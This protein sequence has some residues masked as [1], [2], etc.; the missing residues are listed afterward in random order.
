MGLMRTAELIALVYF[1]YL[2]V[3][4]RLAGPRRA[5]WADAACVAMAAGA[6]FLPRLGTGP[7]AN[8]VRDWIPGAFLLLGYWMAS[9]YKGPAWPAFERALLHL[10]RSLLGRA[11]DGFARRAPRLVLEAL[12]VAYALCY[13]FVP[14]G[15]LWLVLSGGPEDADRFWTAVLL[16]SLPCYGLLPW[17]HTAP[18]R[19][20][21]PDLPVERRGLLA[22]RFNF[23]LLHRTSVHANTFPSGHVASTVAVALTILASQPGAGAAFLAGAG[24]IAV[25]T[26]TGRYH[27]AADAVLGALL[28]ALGFWLA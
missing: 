22:R 13:P 16:A 3:A 1:L 4:G 20:V 9:P 21:E 28:G 17:F 10:D 18:P 12:E 5:R 8:L 2:P 25:A 23:R 15:L 11:L 24:V 7:V 6:A 14:A 27:F 26:V 19:A